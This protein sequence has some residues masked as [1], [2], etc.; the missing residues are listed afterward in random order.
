MNNENAKQKLVL[1]V[2]P[3]TRGIGFALFE[4][5]RQPIDWGVK[6]AKVDKNAQGLLRIQR[7]MDFY[8][9]DVIVVEDYA[10]EGSRRSTRVQQLI[11]DIKRLA[12]TK[13]IK[14]YSYSRSAIRKTFAQSGAKTKYEIAK[15]IAE[16]LPTFAQRLPPVRKPWM[17]E[18]YRMSIFDAVALALTFY[19]VEE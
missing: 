6:D 8:H 3:A 11:K 2:D 16:W 19:S 14:T 4:G 1:A 7:L 10:G 15:K 13:G 17:S 12:Q 5:P 18:D 9:P